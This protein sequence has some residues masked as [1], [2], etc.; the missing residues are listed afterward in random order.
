MDKDLKRYKFINC[1]TGNAIH[2]LSLSENEPNLLG[3]L[4]EER[5]KVAYENNMLPGNVY[6]LLYTTSDFDK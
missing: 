3:L 4:E 2:F 1:V 5:Q 6:Y